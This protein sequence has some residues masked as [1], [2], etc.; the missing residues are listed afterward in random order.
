M[1]PYYCHSGLDPESSFVGHSACG[2]TIYYCLNIPIPRQAVGHPAIPPRINVI[3]I[4]GS[5]AGMLPYYCHSGLDPESRIIFALRQ[6]VV[7]KISS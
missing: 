3:N 4:N 5:I 7:K 2:V 6:D 1:L